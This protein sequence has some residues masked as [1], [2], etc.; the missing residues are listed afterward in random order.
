M[1]DSFSG[2]DL[3][4]VY[5]AFG[6]GGGRRP[7]LVRGRLLPSVSGCGCLD[8][9]PGL[10]PGPVYISGSRWVSAHVSA[11][12]GRLCLRSRYR[13][14]R[15]RGVRRGGSALGVAVPAGL[16]LLQEAFNPPHRPLCSAGGG[17]LDPVAAVVVG[18]P[19]LGGVPKL[20]PQALGPVL[21][22]TADEGFRRGLD[23]LLQALLLDSL[24]F[25]FFDAS[26]PP[27]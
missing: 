4:T 9:F 23:L 24:F 14:V 20:A 22:T 7:L 11:R 26:S 21:Q 25:Y 12:C 5:P 18:P 27:T 3:E 2:L 1:R 16:F 17:I 15:L 13:N 19:A 6:L 8:S 10:D